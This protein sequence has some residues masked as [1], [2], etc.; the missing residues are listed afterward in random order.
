MPAERH[1]RGRAERA[2]QQR[3]RE[4]GPRRSATFSRR[5]FGRRAR[6]TTIA[7]VETVKNWNTMETNPKTAVLGPSAARPM[8]LTCPTKAV[9]TRLISGSASAAPSAGS[10]KASTRDSVRG[11]SA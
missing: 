7:V 3:E 8:A 10:E 11:A 6:G 4:R 9:S 1:Q 2:A 5:R